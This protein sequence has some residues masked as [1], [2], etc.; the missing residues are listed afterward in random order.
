MD[1]IPLIAKL[2]MEAFHRT[3]G[4]S[5]RLSTARPCA[6]RFSERQSGGLAVEV[7]LRARDG[8]AA[9]WRDRTRQSVRAAC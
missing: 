2:K 4:Q 6:N 8:G 5:F 1:V 9:P 7:E 3:R